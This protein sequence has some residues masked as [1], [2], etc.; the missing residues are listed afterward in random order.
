MDVAGDLAA[1]DAV[2]VVADEAAAE[3][4][5]PAVEV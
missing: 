4:L 5:R 2:L 3:G 1:A